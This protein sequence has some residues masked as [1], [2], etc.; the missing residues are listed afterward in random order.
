VTIGFNYPLALICV[1]KYILS[2][3]CC[4]LLEKMIQQLG[5]CWQ[6]SE[7]IFQSS[8][9]IK[10]VC[11]MQHISKLNTVKLCF[12]T[13]IFPLDIVLPLYKLCKED[14]RVDS[15]FGALNILRHNNPSFCILDARP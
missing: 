7:N 14:I 1:M 2:V 5:C 3:S 8:V 12:I 10:S 4:D 15:I 13:Q 9:Y 6:L 11:V